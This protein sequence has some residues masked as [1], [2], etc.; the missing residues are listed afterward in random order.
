MRESGP[1]SSIPW[2]GSGIGYRAELK[3]AIWEHVD[4]IDCLEI[5]T[6]RYVEN[7]QLIEE[8]E[9]LCD[10][11]RVIPHGIG[12]SVGSPRTSST[13]LRDIKRISDIT[14]SPYYSEHLCLT[15]APGLEIG[16]LSPIWFT[17]EV[18]EN[19]IA[20]VQ[21]IQDVLGKP[22]I[23]ENVTYPFE[24]P[25]ADMPQAEFFHRMVTATGCGILLDITNVFINAS[26]H[27]FSAEEFLDQM[28]LDNV[29]QLHMS[30][31]YSVEDGEIVDGHC[32]PPEE[33]IWKLLEA[34]AKRS[35]VLGS[36]LEHDADFPSDFSILLSTL[37]KTREILGWSQQPVYAEGQAVLA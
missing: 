13:Y 14:K 32:R 17:E 5:I 12:L 4:E 20:N 34:F 16:H 28:P 25:G 24:I 22:L 1:L 33:G 37:A 3:K 35:K 6:D 8:V 10:S 36:I 29:V 11:F 2:Q 27:G 9:A 18:L 23:L 7:P 19:T 31:G 26:N 21:Q 30:G 15:R